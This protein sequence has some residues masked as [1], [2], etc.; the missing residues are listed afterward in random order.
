MV[1][2]GLFPFLKFHIIRH[3]Q[4]RKQELGFIN[5]KEPSWADNEG[6]GRVGTVKKWAEV[7]T[8]CVALVQKSSF[9]QRQRSLDVYRSLCPLLSRGALQTEIRQIR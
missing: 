6:R 7:L 1:G 5:C 9:Q 3:E 4:V 2:R 8:M